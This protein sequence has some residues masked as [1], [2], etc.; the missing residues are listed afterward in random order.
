[1]CSFLI[2]MYS[3]FFINTA[4]AEEITTSEG[5]VFDTTTGTITE[6]IGTGGDIVIPT[7]INDIDVITIG[8]NAFNNKSLTSVTIPEGIETIQSQAFQEN[9][10]ENVLLPASLKYIG[11]AVFYGNNFTS[12]SLPSCSEPNFLY[13]GSSSG[14]KYACGDIT[15]DLLSDFAAV[16]EY[17]RSNKWSIGKLEL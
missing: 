7:A 4:F 9:L 3:V 1:M 14:E 15:D 6:Y 5:F 11:E 2:S 12:F 16:C 8:T 17:S 13:W 10:L